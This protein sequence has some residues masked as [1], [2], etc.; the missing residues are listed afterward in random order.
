VHV[1]QLPF[2]PPNNASGVTISATCVSESS[3]SHRLLAAFMSGCLWHFFSTTEWTAS[4]HRVA[5]FGKA[6]LSQITANKCKSE[7]ACMQ[8]VYGSGQQCW[9]ILPEL[10]ANDVFVHH[11]RHHAFS[12]NG[13]AIRRLLDCN[14]LHLF[15]HH[16]SLHVCT[17]ACGVTGPHSIQLPHRC[18]VGIQHS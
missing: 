17:N 16:R 8:N 3:A 18:Q 14:L 10:L 13:A 11:H 9:V 4:H 1:I 6:A 5:N 15:E 12:E 7:P 2:A